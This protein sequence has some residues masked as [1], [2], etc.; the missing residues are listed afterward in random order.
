M[1]LYIIGFLCYVLGC[2][3]LR[4]RIRNSNH[5]RRP[6]QSRPSF[7]HMTTHEAWE[8]VQYLITQEFPFTV[9]KALQFALFRTYGIPSISSLLCETTQLSTP[10]HAPRRYADT[11][12]LVTEFM[13]HEPE[14]RRCNEAIARMNW[15]HGMWLKSGKIKNED[16]LFTL[17]LFVLEVE[18]WIRE[19]E[20]REMTEMELCALGTLFK[21]IGDAMSISYA[22]LSRGP[23]KFVDGLEFTEDLR[24]WSKAYEEQVMVPNQWNRQLAEQTIDILLC[25]VPDSLKP[26]GTNIIVSLMDERLR[27]AM[28]Y[29]LPPP[30]YPKVIAFALQARKLFVKY[31]MPPRPWALRY[32]TLTDPDSKTGRMLFTEY[33]SEPWYVAAT[34]FSLY[35]P[36]AL[37]RR[38]LGRPVPDGKGYKPEGYH[39]FELGPSK[40]EGKGVEECAAT[41]EK[42]LNGRRGGCPFA[43]S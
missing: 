26:V 23:D 33:N 10:Q 39:M 1:L 40:F 28:M 15:L 31:L 41:A 21:S 6:Y 29:E 27:K 22:P 34:F 35:S 24:S 13:V 3:V 2:S 25:N 9:A 5:A 38:A 42:L 32:R 20:W 7:R 14:S 36:L 4:F 8:I 30:M 43:V 17:S 11:T 37:F 12:I 18:R 19:T 16:M